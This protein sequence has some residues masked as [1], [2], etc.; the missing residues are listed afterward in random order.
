ML[1]LP[2]LLPLSLLLLLLFFNAVVANV[3]AGVVG[4]AIVVAVVVTT[5][6]TPPPPPPT[7]TTQRQQWACDHQTNSKNYDKTA[8]FFV[9]IV[10]AIDTPHS[11]KCRRTITRTRT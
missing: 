7:T 10:I 8:L 3:S 1:L 11:T 4:V 6:P 5:L 9:A 2:M